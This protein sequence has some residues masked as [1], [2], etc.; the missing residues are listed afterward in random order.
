MLGTTV[1]ASSRRWWGGLTGGG[2]RRWW[3]HALLS[4]L[5]LLLLRSKSY[6]PQR[7]GGLLLCVGV[8]CCRFGEEWD[9]QKTKAH[10]GP[11]SRDTRLVPRQPLDNVIRS[12]TTAPQ[13]SLLGSPPDAFPGSSTATGP[14]FREVTLPTIALKRALSQQGFVGRVP[15]MAIHATLAPTR[16]TAGRDPSRLALRFGFHGKMKPCAAAKRCLNPKP[17]CC[18]CLSVRGGHGHAPPF[19]ARLPN[20]RKRTN[21]GVLSMRWEIDKQTDV[22]TSDADNI[23]P[24]TIPQSESTWRQTNH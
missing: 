13:F 15:P 8:V 22:P 9:F 21:E 11:T 2:G 16:V 14:P 12:L 1:L 23:S 17:E 7:A 19:V 4:V 20:S 6:A 24:L 5:L 3:A 10:G 18:V